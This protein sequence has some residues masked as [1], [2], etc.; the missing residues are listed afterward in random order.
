MMPTTTLPSPHPISAAGAKTALMPNAY[1][2]LPPNSELGAWGGD[3]PLHWPYRTGRSRN[4]SAVVLGV[5][6]NRKEGARE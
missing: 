1:L 5:N 3:G 4:A 6:V 2:S